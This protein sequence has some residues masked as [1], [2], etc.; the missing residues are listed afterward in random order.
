MF[1][2][3]KCISFAFAVS[4]INIETS[5]IYHRKTLFIH[6]IPVL[7]ICLT[8]LQ[9]TQQGSTEVEIQL[10]KGSIIGSTFIPLELND[11]THYNDVIMGAKASQITSLVIVNSTVI[12]AQIKGNTKAPRHWLCEGNSPVTGEFPAQMASNAE[13]ISIWWRHHELPEIFTPLSDF[14][15]FHDCRCTVYPMT[16]PHAFVSLALLCF[17]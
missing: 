11:K 3:I 16:R 5:I 9:C 4:F 7:H 17:Y 8:I 10:R 2:S 15:W 12:Q 6:K 13:N 1:V 14:H